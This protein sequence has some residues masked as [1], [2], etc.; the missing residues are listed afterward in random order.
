MVYWIIDWGGYKI[1]LDDLVIPY[2]I[3][4][5]VIIYF[6]RLLRRW[7]CF[8]HHCCKIFSHFVFTCIWMRMN[9]SV[10]TFINVILSIYYII[11]IIMLN[12]SNLSSRSLCFLSRTAWR[13]GSG[14]IHSRNKHF[15]ISS[16]L[17]TG[18]PPN[19]NKMF[20]SLTETYFYIPW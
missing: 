18:S 16:V 2:D 19:V 3:V 1:L 17:F 20:P 12:L 10:R 5:L 9:I 14:A 11:F 7:S 8:W 6:E 15:I 13:P 4:T